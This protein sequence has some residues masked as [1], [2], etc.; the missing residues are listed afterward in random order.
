MLGQF[1]KLSEPECVD[2]L[3]DVAQGDSHWRFIVFFEITWSFGVLY[4]I[5][6]FYVTL[7][8]ALCVDAVLE[9]KLCDYHVAGKG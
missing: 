6:R 3:K 4:W 8:S 7:R 9:P 5:S 1:G 2:V